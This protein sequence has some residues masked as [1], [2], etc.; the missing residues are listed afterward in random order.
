MPAP[1]AKLITSSKTN[2]T[3][4]TTPSP[5]QYISLRFVMQKQEQSR[6][7]W[8]AVATSTA[9]YFDPKSI[10]IQ[11][12]VVNNT[13]FESSCCE[14]GSTPSCNRDGYLDRALR[15]VGHFDARR[16]GH[17]VLSFA[18]IKAQ[19]DVKCP[20]GV[21]I[22][23]AGGGG[24]FVVIDGYSTAEELSLCDPA[25][26]TTTIMVDYGIFLTNY[27]GSGKWTH[28]YYTKP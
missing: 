12:Q 4:P 17:G 15:T 25:D 21:R 16:S 7:C 18:E 26:P 6:W 2:L 13:L 1:L 20:I 9:H 11:C 24:H 5:L 22:E 27:L 10:W 23:W 19:I 28:H 14:D 8:T 3:R